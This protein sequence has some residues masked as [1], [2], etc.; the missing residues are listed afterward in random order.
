M[1][2]S[3]RAGLCGPYPPAHGVCLPCNMFWGF[4]GEKVT[5]HLQHILRGDQS[6]ENEGN[7]LAGA[8]YLENMSFSTGTSKAG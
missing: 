5:D 1:L 7:K 2:L 4:T 3:P 8:D 6:G